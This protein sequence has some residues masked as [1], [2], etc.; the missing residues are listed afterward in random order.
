MSTPLVAHYTR[1]VVVAKVGGEGNMVVENS[2]E[3]KEGRSEM[4][5]FYF[6]VVLLLL[7]QLQLQVQ[8]TTDTQKGGRLCTSFISTT[9]HV[10]ILLILQHPPA[11]TPKDWLTALIKIQMPPKN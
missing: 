8:E 3:K 4:K 1:K 5:F 11:N 7:L 10:T 9:S 2:L 6:L